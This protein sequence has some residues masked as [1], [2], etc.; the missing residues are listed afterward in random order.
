MFTQ[1]FHEEQSTEAYSLWRRNNKAREACVPLRINKERV[2]LF[3]HPTSLAR[4]P[5]ARFA[6]RSKWRASSKASGTRDADPRRRL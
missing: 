1:Q 3:L 5:A 2:L 4:S 6:Y